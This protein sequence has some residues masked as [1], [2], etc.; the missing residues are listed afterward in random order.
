[1]SHE[2]IIMRWQNHM[3]IYNKHTGLILVFIHLVYFFV[4]LNQYEIHSTFTLSCVTVCT[5][6]PQRSF[7]VI[8]NSASEAL[9]LWFSLRQQV[10]PSCLSHINSIEIE[11][12]NHHPQLS[13]GSLAGCWVSRH[14]C[15]VACQ[16]VFHNLSL[17]F[18]YYIRKLNRH[19]ATHNML[20]SF[21]SFYLFK[22]KPARWYLK[23]AIITHCGGFRVWMCCSNQGFNRCPH[24]SLS[25]TT[26]TLVALTGGD[27]F[28]FL[29]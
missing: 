13:C 27:C 9:S 8:L 28:F 17:L 2:W 1:M 26:V 21:S 6:L 4:W 11:K 12:N 16:P 25:F 18:L 23:Y 3:W 22:Q 10:H 5:C 7:T 24:N 19:L 20:F 14:V 15:L 29:K